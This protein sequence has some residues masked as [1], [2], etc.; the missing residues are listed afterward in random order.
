M[1]ARGLALNVAGSMPE[2]FPDFVAHWVSPAASETDPVVSIPC[3]TAP[4]SA[5]PTGS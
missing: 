4:A 5:A 3:S 2:E 1:S